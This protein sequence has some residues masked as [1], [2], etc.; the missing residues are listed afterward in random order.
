MS[1]TLIMIGIVVLC[2]FILDRR[3]VSLIKRIDALEAQAAK[4]KTA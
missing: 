4:D 1:D 3:T 2:I